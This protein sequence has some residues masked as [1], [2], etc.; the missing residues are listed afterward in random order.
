MCQGDAKPEEGGLIARLI[1][2]VGTG[3]P[4]EVEVWPDNC[5]TVQ[6]FSGMLSQWNVGMSGVIGLRYE[7]LPFVLEL[8]GVCGEQRREVYDGLREMERA[9][10]KKINGR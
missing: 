7:A 3:E 9:A 4:D 6:V 2:V 10:V 1:E 5:L 8:Y